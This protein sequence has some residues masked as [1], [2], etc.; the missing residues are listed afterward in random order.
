M[1]FQKSYY[2]NAIDEL[3]KNEDVMKDLEELGKL[4][5]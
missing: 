5:K 2:A 4:I 3:G 1:L